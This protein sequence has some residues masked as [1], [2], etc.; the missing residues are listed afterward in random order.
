MLNIAICDDDIPTTGRMEL[1]IQQIAKR[2]F[3]D[4][5]IEVFWNGESLADAVKTGNCFDM[6]YLDIEMGPEDGIST[7]KRIRQC[8]KNV[9]IIYVTSYESYMK[10]TFE[11]YGK[12]NEIENI[13]KDCK[14]SF[15]R[16]HQSFLVNY[17]HVDGQAYDFVVMDNGKKISISE[18]RRKLISEQYCSMEGPFYADG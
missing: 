4:A 11:L 7:A 12:L 9:L 3:V 13:L 18:H 2:N 17:K 14:T 5:E 1:L 15:L 6:I 16:V 8:D 10:E